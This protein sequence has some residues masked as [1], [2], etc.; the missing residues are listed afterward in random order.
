[1]SISDIFTLVCVLLGVLSAVLVAFH[2]NVLYA[3]I[4]LVFSLLSVAGVYGVLG[5][6]FLA[7]TQLII[8]VGGIIVVM[9][10]AI[11]MSENIY[12]KRFLDN[13]SKSIVPLTLCLLIGFGL[14]RL[15]VKTNWPV[16]DVLN[17][18][19]S[20]SVAAIGKALVGPYALPFEYVSIVL[21]VGL[22][23]AV[24]VARPRYSE[25]DREEG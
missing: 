15:V 20:S 18:V 3:A 25:D 14:M 12:Q 22:I 8:Y 10:F 21:L 1:M 7:A 16:S 2:P 5:A 6:D 17:Q 19:R 24:V 11:M 4:A 23:G 9:L 13:V